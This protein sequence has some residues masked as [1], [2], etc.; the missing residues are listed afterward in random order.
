MTSPSFGQTNEEKEGF[1]MNQERAILAYFKSP[2]DAE[3][4]AQRLRNEVE[5]ADLQIERFSNV[6]RAGMVEFNNPIQG[7]DSHVHLVEGK[8]NMLDE[9]VGILLSADTAV[10]GMSGD[11]I[12]TR[13]I[14]L[15]VVCPPP[16]VEQAVQIINE[17]GGQH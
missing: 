9:R 1:Q 11:Y 7:I 13:D 10:S 15:T 3:K 6:P 14:L 17:C 16:S 5:V 12:E 2:A 4:A 8:Q